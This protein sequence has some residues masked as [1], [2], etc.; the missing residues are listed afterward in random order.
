MPGKRDVDDKVYGLNREAMALRVTHRVESRSGKIK[1]K[2]PLILLYI[3][4][5]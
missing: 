4:P 2:L 1:H 3:V 5:K